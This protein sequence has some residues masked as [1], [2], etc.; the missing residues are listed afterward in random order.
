MNSHFIRIQ[1][2]ATTRTKYNEAKDCYMQ[3]VAEK[4]EAERQYETFI[5]RVKIQLVEKTKDFEQLREKLI[6]HDIDQLRIKVQEE[7]EIQ[8]KQQ[9]QSIEQELGIVTS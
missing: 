1:E 9:L 5:E 6:P 7:L 2:L 3:T 4:L 8:H